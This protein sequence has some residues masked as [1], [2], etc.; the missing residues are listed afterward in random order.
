MTAVLTE[1]VKEQ[2]KQIES[3]ELKN[4]QLESELQSLREEMDQI[5]GMLAK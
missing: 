2:Q 5:K 4:Q 3:Q 1:A